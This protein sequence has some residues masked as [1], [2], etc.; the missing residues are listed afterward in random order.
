LHERDELRAVVEVLSRPD[1]R[2]VQFGIAA[3]PH[4]RVFLNPDGGVVFVG[5]NLP[6]LPNGRAF[7]LWL[8]PA[9]GAPQPLSLF[10][11]NSAGDSVG[12]SNKAFD[13]S[14][15]S[16]VAVSIEPANGSAAPTTKPI[17]VVSVG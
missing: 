9:K 7:E 4:G 12:V 16:A 11:A 8:I 5:A 15:V 1:T 10:Q 3:N 17:L 14:Q 2:A 13:I 6:Q